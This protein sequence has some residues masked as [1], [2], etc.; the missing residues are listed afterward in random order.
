MKNY[1]LDR[2]LLTT[3]RRYPRKREYVLPDSFC[4]LLIAIV[5]VFLLTY[6]P[7]ILTTFLASSI[8]KLL[9]NPPSSLFPPRTSFSRARFSPVI[10]WQMAVSCSTVS[11]LERRSKIFTLTTALAS[12]PASTIAR[13]FISFKHHT[14]A[15]KDAV[16]NQK[17]FNHLKIAF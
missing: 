16:T 8:Q 17:L 2:N 6:S 14:C 10:L 4:R 1:P 7:I 3:S 15:I 9:L 5:F 11:P 13:L 12:L